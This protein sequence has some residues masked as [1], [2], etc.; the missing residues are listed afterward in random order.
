GPVAPTQTLDRH[1]LQPSRRFPVR[2]CFLP[3][4]WT[5]APS[6]QSL[7]TSRLTRQARSATIEAASLPALFSPGRPDRHCG[8]GTAAYRGY[9][10]RGPP[11][12]A[13]FDR[14]DGDRQQPRGSANT[15]VMPDARPTSGCRRAPK[16]R[17]APHGRPKSHTLEWSPKTGATPPHP[18]GSDAAHGTRPESSRE[19]RHPARSEETDTGCRYTSYRRETERNRAAGHASHRIW[20]SRQR[21]ACTAPGRPN[22][23]SRQ[24]SQVPD[25]PHQ[26]V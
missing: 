16:N 18:V 1:A 3:S 9:T 12:H 19:S 6:S 4:K 11:P 8:F 17:S 23:H 5:E 14:A 22:R 25:S 24:R 26:R 10:T 21:R 7:S 15:R 20:D 2:R 13:P